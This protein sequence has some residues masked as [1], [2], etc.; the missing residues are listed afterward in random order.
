[1]DGDDAVRFCKHCQRH[2]Y[3]LSAMT[4]EQVEELLVTA[5]GRLCAR[6][7]QRADGTVLTSDC[8]PGRRRIRRRRALVGLGAGVASMLGAA[9]LSPDAPRAPHPSDLGRWAGSPYANA[10]EPRMGLIGS[11]SFVEDDLDP[12][13]SGIMGAIGILGESEDLAEDLAD[14]LED[15]PKPHK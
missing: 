14:V 8:A 4:A 11:E 7:Y 3:Q 9:A 1:M 13:A 6:F 2:V 5:T 10:D 12:G 15:P